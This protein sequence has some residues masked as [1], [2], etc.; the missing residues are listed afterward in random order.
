MDG[1]SIYEIRQ[2]YLT[3]G[4]CLG[5]LSG[6]SIAKTH[7]LYPRPKITDGSNTEEE[8]EEEEEEESLLKW[9]HT[10]TIKQL[11]Y[12]QLNTGCMLPEGSQPVNA[13]CRLLHVEQFF[14][15]TQVQCTGASAKTT[16]FK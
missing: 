8:E 2:N 7:C 9:K 13:G 11:S 14:N 5:Y 6:I 1:D 4:N 15:N 12:E 10:V 16:H 3:S